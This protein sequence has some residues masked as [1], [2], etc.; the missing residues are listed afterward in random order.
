MRQLRIWKW[1]KRGLV[2]GPSLLVVAVCFGAIYQAMASRF[3]LGAKPPGRLIDV[4][5]YRL[6]LYCRG[7]GKSTIVVIPGVGVWSVQWRKIQDAL[8]QETRICTYDRYGY[9]WSDLGPSTAT[10]GQA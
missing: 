2:L 7:R 8:A 3:D 5:G 6:H 4:G 10:A 1:M 9:G